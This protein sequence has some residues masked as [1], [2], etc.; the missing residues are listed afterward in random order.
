MMTIEVPQN[1]S[2]ARHLPARRLPWASFAFA[3]GA[4]ATPAIVAILAFLAIVA[5]D[6]AAPPSSAAAA[7]VLRW[8]DIDS[9]ELRSTALEL[10]RAVELNVSATATIA[11]DSK[12]LVAYPWILDSESRKV[13][14]TVD[15]GQAKRAGR[16]RDKGLML[17]KQ[18]QALRLDAG[19]YE[20][21]FSTY[22]DVHRIDIKGWFGIRFGHRKT[23]SDAGHLEDDDWK[24]A[25]TCR[26]E[27]AGAVTAGEK[28]RPKFSPLLRIEHPGNNVVE[29]IPFRLDAPATVVVYAIGEYD[30]KSRGMADMGWIVRADTRERV[31]EMNPDNTHRAGGAQKNR[32]FRDTVRLEAGTYLLCYATD[33]SHGWGDWNLNPPHDPEFWGIALFDHGDARAH[34]KGN[35]E[36]PFVANTLVAIDHQPDNTFLMRGIKVKRPIQVRVFALGEYDEGDGRFADFGWI[37]EARTHRTIWTMTAENTKPAGGATKNRMADEMV[38]LAPG[39]YLVCNWTDDSHA[40]GEW[41]ASPPHDADAWGIQVWGVGKNFDR[42]S[43]E[44]Y[45]E[46]RDSK[47]LAQLLGIGD[48][49]HA[50]E[51]F[52]LKEKLKANI[53]AIGE[54]NHGQMVDYGWLKRVDGQHTGVIW[55]MR[56]SD[57]VSAGGNDKNRRQEEEIELEPGSY[58]LH[59]VTDDSH[60]FEDWNAN[61]PDQ[62][63]LWGVAVSRLN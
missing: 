48:D 33:D 60:S 55:R 41:N 15:P 49:R 39:D 54:G 36:D 58:E 17:V 46:D 30:A 63:H 40:F 45:V 11:E 29:R 27:D 2:P 4:G 23:E 1:M 34:F 19:Q 12:Q 53:L 18:D 26:D 6:L 21:Y 16:R 37:E 59:Y 52:Q 20:V 7:S 35:V 22:G 24:L 5:I 50:V 57:T 31:W 25:I 51:R 38:S 10:T 14:W 8:D 61:P 9:N 43:V 42:K 3:I 44:E 32:S 13:V 47:I 62:P 56:Y 28:A